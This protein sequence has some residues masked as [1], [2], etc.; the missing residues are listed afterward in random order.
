MFQTSSI[1]F[2]SG[3]R[4]GSSNKKIQKLPHSQSSSVEFTPPVCID[5][6]SKTRTSYGNKKT[7]FYRHLHLNREILGDIVALHDPVP[8]W[9]NPTINPAESNN[10][11]GVSK[12]RM[13]C[14]WRYDAGEDAASSFPAPQLSTLDVLLVAEL[15]LRAIKHRDYL[16]IFQRLIQVCWPK[17]VVRNQIRLTQI[18]PDFEPAI[19]EISNRLTRDEG[20]GVGVQTIDISPQCRARMSRRQMDPGPV[21]CSLSR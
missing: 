18:P 4:A 9:R 21:G 8:R 1:G 7:R 20:P 17:L 5:A 10:C 12:I 16:E 13:S 19:K 3:V 2:H 15:E 11:V 14:D 6:L